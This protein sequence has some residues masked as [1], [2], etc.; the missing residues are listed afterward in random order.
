MDESLLFNVMV[1]KAKHQATWLKVDPQN[2]P[3]TFVLKP[4]PVDVP[5]N[6]QISGTV[7]DDQ[8]KPIRGAAVFVAG[9]QKANQT[10]YGRA[11][12]IDRVC[13]TA[14][15]GKFLLTSTV[16]YERWSLQCQARGFVN[17][18]TELVPTGFEPVSIAM[19]RGVTLTGKVLSQSGDPVAGHIV[20]LY[21]R[22]LPGSSEILHLMK[23]R[24]IAT[25]AE[26]MFR[27]NALGPSMEW[28]IYSAIDDR[29]DVEFFQSSFFE[30]GVDKTEKDLGEF[31]VKGNCRISGK[32]M[33]PEGES[34]PIESRISVSRKHAWKHQQAKVDLDTG[35]YSLPAMPKGETLLVSVS[36]DGFEVV[37]AK[38][39]HQIA[40]P[41]VGSSAHIVLFPDTDEVK[42]DIPMIRLT[43]S[44]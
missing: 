8:G 39:K 42:I 25:D 44:E 23:E 29:D 4:I 22:R 34:L 20:G 2:D 16:P 10:M 43:A 21:P 35:E 41:Y 17:A 3:A 26:G 7:V 38:Q 33:L 13:I 14:D 18:K 32:I 9:F 36:I 15:D 37:E 27:F 31:S 19:K 24:I 1:A 30:T 5:E 6:Q 12:G 11:E 28:T 40:R